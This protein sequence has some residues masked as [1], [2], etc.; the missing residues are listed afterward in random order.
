MNVRSTLNLHAFTYSVVN[1]LRYEVLQGQIEIITAVDV[2]HPSSV[3]VFQSGLLNDATPLVC[4]A[5]LTW[6]SLKYSTAKK[7]KKLDTISE[8]YMNARKIVQASLLVFVHIF[9][10]NVENAI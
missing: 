5:C 4:L 7:V 9:F 10:R 6:F 8:E 1:T 2:F 3:D